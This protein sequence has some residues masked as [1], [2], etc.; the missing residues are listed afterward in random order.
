MNSM[1]ASE[2]L[3]AIKPHA[4]FCKG[5]INPLFSYM[6]LTPEGRAVTNNGHVTII[7]EIGYDGEGILVPYDKFCQVL[8]VLGNKEFSITE[9]N[10]S[11][12]IKSGAGTHTLLTIDV[13]DFPLFNNHVDTMTEVRIE[14]LHEFISKAIYAA[15]TSDFRKVLL[16]VNLS[17]SK[18]IFKV[19][20][21]DGK[22]L[23]RVSAPASDLPDFSINVPVD[24]AKLMVQNKCDGFSFSNNK[25][26]FVTKVMFVS[27]VTAEG[28]YPEVDHV[29]P[30]D[31][32]TIL[33]YGKDDALK[34]VK[35][36]MVTSSDKTNAVIFDVKKTSVT[37]R[38]F[39]V[40]VGNSESA[41]NCDCNEEFEFAVNGKMFIEL[42]A[43]IG[44]D[45]VTMT[46]KS[47]QSPIQVISGD[48]IRVL[49]PI[50]LADVRS[51]EKDE[52]D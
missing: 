46:I 44:E 4:P 10:G 25:I 21:T 18:G 5:I 47:P 48:T 14:N 12:V 20:G 27:A 13:S 50:K 19:V 9:K 36:C 7:S 6:M 30:K 26:Q 16:C 49:M 29:I 3:S 34:A 32:Q 37:C 1:I 41:F 51:V 39:S 40:D 45:I 24:I 33:S 17:H 28:K 2:V 52:N 11:V 23:C 38:S 8:A 42:M 43:Q 22:K 15:A 35:R 31:A